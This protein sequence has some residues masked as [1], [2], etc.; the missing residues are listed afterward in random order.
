MRRVDVTGGNLSLMDYCTAGPQFASGGFI[1]DSG[2][3][4]VING[5]QQQWLTRNS[6]VGALVQ[7]R[8][9]PGLRRRRGRPRRRRVP[10]PA[11]HDARHHAG[12]PG[13][14][15]PV[16]STPPGA[17]KVRVPAAQVDSRGATWTDGTT[18]GRT[19][20][21]TEFFVARPSDSVA[22]INSQ[23]ARGQAPAA[24]PGRVRRRPEHRRPA[25]R[26]RRPR[27]GAGDAH[28]RR[29]RGPDDGRRRAGRRRRRRH[30]RRGHGRVAG[31]AA[32]RH[33]AGNDGSR[34]RATPRNPTTLNDVYFRVGGPH[35]G[36]AD[37]SLEVNSDDV[38][39]DHT[40]VWRADHG[41]EGFTAR[42]E[43]R[44]RPLGDQHGPQRRGRQRRRRDRDGPVRRA[45]PGA[46]HH[47]ERR[48]RHRRAVPERAAV[49]PA[50]AGRLDAPAARSATPA[51]RS[52]TTSRTHQL[53][54]GGVYVF[55]RTT[56]RS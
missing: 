33:E 35:V 11:L 8:L 29:R 50:D 20:P 16:T 5:S 27:P 47:L 49:R 32:R 48:A 44:H 10:E 28:R 25:R 4:R 12:E 19:V 54:G 41:V 17:Y 13:E 40:W 55:N 45:L 53:Y 56:R 30:R 51:T 2:P 15:L 14:A 52:A 39:I 1:A 34:V 21:L 26:H 24:H 31:A 7:R 37:V 38:L 36:K 6:E 9:E 23:L 42:R 3:A 46:Q 18:A 43:R 22:T